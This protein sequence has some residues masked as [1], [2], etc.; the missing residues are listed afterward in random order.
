MEMEQRGGMKHE[1]ADVLARVADIL[2]DESKRRSF[3]EDP[4]GTLQKEGLDPGKL[5]SRAI[6]ALSRLSPQEAGLLVRLDD[7]LKDA[8]LV[9]E[10]PNGG[11]VSFF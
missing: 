7:K 1:A 11:R 9:V 4:R 10:G 2:R 5:P 8:G 6:D 3:A